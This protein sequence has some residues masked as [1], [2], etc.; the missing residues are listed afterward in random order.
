MY[1]IFF[2]YGSNN[3]VNPYHHRNSFGEMVEKPSINRK[4]ANEHWGIG[5]RRERVN[6]NKTN[7]DFSVTQ[8]SLHE[9]ETLVL[10]LCA[11]NESD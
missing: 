10:D 1:A 9:K 8:K 2:Y 3:R 11:Q 6:N 5:R 7:N 4:Y